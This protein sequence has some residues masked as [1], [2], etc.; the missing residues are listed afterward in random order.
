MSILVNK[1]THVVIQGGVAGQNAARRMADLDAGRASATA[2]P[3]SP[4]F[5]MSG[6]EPSKLGEG[7]RLE[8]NFTIGS[9][10]L[11]SFD[12]GRV[13][14][15]S[16]KEYAGRTQFNELSGQVT[17]DRGAVALRNVAIGAGALN[18]GASADIAQ[19]GAL[20][21]RI[22]ADVKASGSAR[23]LSATLHLG[24][25]IKEPQVRN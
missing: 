9:G 18:A 21:G 19:G 24:G 12:L 7:G 13:L 17:Y 23:A 2:S 22:V 1:D 8:G 15:T 6:S 4:V 5:S 14:R 25:T 3:S 10:V 20:S 11:G 16:G